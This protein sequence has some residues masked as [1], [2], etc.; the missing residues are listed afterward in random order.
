[1]G[2]VT[3]DVSTLK[4]VLE[5]ID[6][7]KKDLSTSQ[8]SSLPTLE[9]LARRTTTA[10]QL[11]SSSIPTLRSLQST[12]PYLKPSAGSFVVSNSQTIELKQQLAQCAQTIKEVLDAINKMEQGEE[13]DEKKSTRMRLLKY[14]KEKEG[15]GVESSELMA[16]LLGAERDGGRATAKSLEVS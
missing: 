7:L 16:Q 10:T 11:L 12:L 14:I 3:Y 6:S 5:G 15:E 2:R 1:M 13:G 8:S 4:E 9:A